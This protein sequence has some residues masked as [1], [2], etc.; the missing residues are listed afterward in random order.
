MRNDRARGLNRC[1]PCADRLRGRLLRAFN[2]QKGMRKDLRRVLR[3]R[4]AISP[5]RSTHN[6]TAFR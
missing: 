3:R 4:S 5:S 6:D 1:R 2:T